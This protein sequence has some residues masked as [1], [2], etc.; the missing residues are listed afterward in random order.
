[1]SFSIFKTGSCSSNKEFEERLRESE[2]LDYAAKHW[3]EHTATVEDQIRELACSFLSHGKL[4][5]CATQ[6]LSCP[7]YR[8][9]NYSQEY[10]K[11]S[12]GLHLTARFGLSIVLEAMLPSQ[13]KETALA[14]ERR[15]SD[16]HTL[17]YLAAEHGHQRMVKLL[18]DKGADVNAQ[19]GYYGNALQGGFR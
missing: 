15:D 2:F 9:E 14:L 12:T 4:V 19:G 11:D 7:T 17:L 6:V 5:S 8:Y 1:L 13:E 10:P 3:G 16:G 18:L